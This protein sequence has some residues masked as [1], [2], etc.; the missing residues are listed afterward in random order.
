MPLERPVRALDDD[1]D[2]YSVS[3]L[4]SEVRAVLD[5]SFPVLWV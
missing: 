5:G 3:R 1:R 4:A 2:I